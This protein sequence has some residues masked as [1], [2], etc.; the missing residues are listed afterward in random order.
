M[1]N[2]ITIGGTTRILN[3]AN[4]TELM[5]LSVGY[6]YYITPENNFLYGNATQDAQL[7][8]PTPNLIGELNNN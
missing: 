3:D 1:A 2:D 5:N 6:R 4:G 7:F 8:L